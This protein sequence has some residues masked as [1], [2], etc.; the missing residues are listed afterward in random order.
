MLW[1]HGYSSLNTLQGMLAAKSLGIPVLVRAEPWLGDRD[2]SGPTLAIKRL[3]FRLLRG[4][5]DGALA[6]R[7]TERRVLAPL[8]RRGFSAVIGCRMRSTTII[9]KAAA[10][11]HARG[12]LRCRTELNLDPAR[13][14]ILFASKLQSRKRCGDL[15]EAYKISLRG[16]GRGLIW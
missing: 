5:V 9:F 7:D 13:P 15:V 3:F 2:R 16:V 6:D 8:S 14:V 1:V 12:D 4:L 10:R 11:R